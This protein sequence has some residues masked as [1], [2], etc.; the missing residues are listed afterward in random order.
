MDSSKQQ[1]HP[2]QPPQPPQRPAPHVPPGLF[3]ALPKSIPEPEDY[4]R[5]NQPTAVRDGVKAPPRGMP[6]HLIKLLDRQYYRSVNTREN[7]LTEPLC[8]CNRPYEKCEKLIVF[9]FCGHRMHQ[10]CAEKWLK[11]SGCC[12]YCT[13]LC[14]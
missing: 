12:P 8:P 9:P 4:V 3:G 13:K 1:Q 14:G 2:Q 10:R 11:L 6:P 7:G 5:Y